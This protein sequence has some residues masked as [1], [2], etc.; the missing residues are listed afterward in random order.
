LTIIAPTDPAGRILAENQ[1]VPAYQ[2]AAD[3]F[4]KHP[5]GR[6]SLV[7]EPPTP[8]LASPLR[9]IDLNRGESQTVTLPDGKPA[10]VTLIDVQTQVDPIRGAVREATVKVE[11]NGT[12][13]TLPSGNYNLPVTV[14]G[15]QAD[16]P[17]TRDYNANSTI[18]HWGLV[19]DA[20]IRL[21]P[22]GKS[23]IDPATFTYPAR[24]RWFASSTQ[25]ANEPTYVDGGEKPSLKSIYYHSGLDIGGAEGMVDVV[26]ATDGIVVSAGGK[27][28]P[29]LDLTST[30]IQPR[31][32][33]V[34]LLDDR[35]WFYRYS[36]MASIDPAITPG[37]T[38]SMGQTIGVLGKEGGSGGWT[39]LHFEIKSRQPSGRWGTEEGY[40]FLW[41]TALREQKPEFIAVARPHRLTWTRDPVTLDGSKSWARPGNAIAS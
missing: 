8:R 38:V 18:D 16:C 26:A 32:D 2:V 34:Y 30:P 3:A 10:T 23:W 13:I 20:R 24:Q 9:T 28:L 17:I 41:E 7:I 36:H 35:G 27:N 40:A 11:V 22:A 6:L 29:G 21:W 31:Y 25:M 5:E 37:T 14:A 1:V 12:P 19:K 15:V 33:V 39:H 4:A